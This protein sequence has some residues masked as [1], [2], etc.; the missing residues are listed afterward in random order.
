MKI[1]QSVCV[2]KNLKNI[3]ISDKYKYIFVHTPKCAGSS[4]EEGLLKNEY[5]VSDEILNRKFWLNEL[6]SEIKNKFWIGNIEGVASAPQHFTPEKYQHRFPQKYIKYFKFAFVRNPWG[7]A[8][9]EWKYF[10]KVLNLNL[11]LKKSLLSKYPFPDHNLDQIIFTRNCDF[12]GR[13][14]TLQQD[15]NIVCDTI[16]I[17]QQQLPHTNKTK[18]KHYTEYYDDETREI[19]AEKHVKDIEYFGYKFG[20]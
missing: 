9:S 11:T 10:N 13:F 14:E 19:V 7:K 16:G 2:F 12:V 8:V 3:V 20:E 4:I 1:C 6:N 5:N 17:P 15:F 18:H